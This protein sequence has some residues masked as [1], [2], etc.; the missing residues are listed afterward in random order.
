MSKNHKRAQLTATVSSALVAILQMT[1]GLAHA[2]SGS[3]PGTSLEEVVVTAQ[4]RDE[5]LKDVP[6][7]VTAITPETLQ[8]TGVMDSVALTRITPGLNFVTVGT[9]SAVSLRGVTSSGSFV[10]DSNN[11]ATYI[12]G[13]A[14]PFGAGNLNNLVGVKQI[15]VLKGPQGTLYGRNAMGGAIVITTLDPS[16]DFKFNAMAQYASF[17]QRTFSAYVSGPIWGDKLAANF[18]VFRDVDDGYIKDRF[19]DARGAKTDNMTLRA[20]L[21]FVPTDSTRAVLTWEWYHNKD[22]RPHSSNLWHGQTSEAARITAVGGP[23]AYIE[24]DPEYMALTFNPIVDNNSVAY[25]A[26]LEQDLPFATLKWNNGF[27]QTT[28]NLRRDQDMLPGRL[29]ELQYDTDDTDIQSELTAI[30]RG[31][32]P[33]SWLAGAS[34]NRQDTGLWQIVSSTANAA[35]GFTAR[36]TPSTAEHQKSISD[37]YAAYGEVN[38]KVTDA[39][40]L[41]AG[42]RYSEDHVRLFVRRISAITLLPVQNPAKAPGDTSPTDVTATYKATTPRLSVRYA[43]NPQSN[44]YFTYSKGYK[45]GIFVGSTFGANPPVLP[46]R[47]T[48]YEVGYKLASRRV[49]L[50]LAAFIYDYKDLQVSRQITPSVSEVSN[51]ATVTIRGLEADTT[52]EPIDDLTIHAAAAYTHARYDTFPSAPGFIVGP[53]NPILTVID[54]SGKHVLRTPDYQLNLD[55]TY[56]QR[57][58]LGGDL[59]W[60]VQNFWSGEFFYDVSNNYYQP[61]YYK[62]GASVS[63]ISPNDRW[64]LTAFGNNLTNT[65]NL[66]NLQVSGLMAQ[67][68]YDRPRTFGVRVN[69]KY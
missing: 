33:L 2:Q 57:G 45:A 58:V 14:Q 28:A 67:A 64:R 52:F 37:G 32:G 50:N 47:L 44:V 11:V 26:L 27:R 61:S 19:R 56:R 8:R 39:L 3:A 60:N 25:T 29:R 23:G 7:S 40:T 31:D 6:I 42:L 12:D 62:L 59:E 9:N 51:A 34:F 24:T 55:A 10:G 17:K 13:I 68:S 5:R 41:T 4:R 46:E 22:N 16:F 18:T 65:H 38:Y 66:T 43:L 1:P 30:S 49:S 15:E 21:L 54:A 36:P 35:S 69:F 63:W 20:K 53:L 48:A